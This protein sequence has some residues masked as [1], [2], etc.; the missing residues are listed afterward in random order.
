MV[1]MMRDEYC[2]GDSEADQAQAAAVTAI[3]PEPWQGVVANWEECEAPEYVTALLLYL[4]GEMERVMGNRLQVPW[5]APDYGPGH[6]ITDVFEWRGFDTD[7][8][9][10]GPTKP[11]FEIVKPGMPKVKVRWYKR[12]GRSVSCNRAL[13]ASTWVI[14][15]NACLASIRSY[16][17]PGPLPDISPYSAPKETL[18]KC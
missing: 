11:Q 12:L 3:T 16:D 5:Q 6:V 14:V 13:T 15:F 8:E 9:D 2:F 17:A 4:R 7:A 18:R 10:A 1:Q